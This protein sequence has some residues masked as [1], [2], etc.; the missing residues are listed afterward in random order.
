MTQF[1]AERYRRRKEFL[2]HRSYSLW[3]PRRRRSIG[4]LNWAIR[5]V[6]SC[7]CIQGHNMVHKCYSCPTANCIK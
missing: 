7:K 4:Q 2:E 3:S 5:P 1:A 6:S